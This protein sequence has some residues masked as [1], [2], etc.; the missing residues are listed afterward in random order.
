VASIYI[1]P[2]QLEDFAALMNAI[3]RDIDLQ[4]RGIAG[5]FVQ[6]G[7]SWRDA[8]YA[9][10]SQEMQAAQQTMHRYLQECETYVT[11][12]KQKAAAARSMQDVR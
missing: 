11:F 7:E 12:L 8:E 10:F 9:R 6:L 4:L 1:D 2:E 5:G 3:S